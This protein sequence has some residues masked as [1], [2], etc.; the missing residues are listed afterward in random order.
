M[1]PPADLI[2]R[3][4]GK[5]YLEGALAL[6]RAERVVFLIVDLDATATMEGLHG[7]YH[8]AAGEWA[9]EGADALDEIGAHESA[10]ILREVNALFPGGAP[11]RDREA[12]RDQL[13]G[14]P[15]A[16]LERLEALGARFLAYPD[17]LGGKLEQYAARHRS[18]L[19][20]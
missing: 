16:A 12:R 14:L 17:G 4:T 8:S 1:E 15:D 6:N 10:A 5:G 11:A 18:E 20:G 3:V 19:T 9:A 7:Y 2:H 13:A